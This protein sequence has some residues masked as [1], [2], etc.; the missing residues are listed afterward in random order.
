M[1]LHKID[2]AYVTNKIK[3]HKEI[4]DILIKK[5]NNSKYETVY[6]YPDKIKKTDFYLENKKNE[7]SDLFI[8]NCLEEIRESHLSL[9]YSNYKIK[10]IWFQEYA[11]MDYHGWHNHEDV[12]FSN[13]YYLKLE[14]ENYA[15]EILNPFS[16]EVISVQASEGDIV[17][18][19]AYLNHRSP[20]NVSEKN[21]IVIVFNTI[22]SP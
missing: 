14:R 8:N 22:A 4:K 3:N 12:T 21:K 18:F 20:V 5:I 19:P 11:K 10:N 9:G 17:T 6:N 7:W 2:G 1:I 13:V 15:T 16:R